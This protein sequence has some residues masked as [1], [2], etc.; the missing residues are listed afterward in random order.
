MKNHRFN[1]IGRPFSYGGKTFS[2]V[3]GNLTGSYNEMMS[4]LFVVFDYWGGRQFTSYDGGSWNYRQFYQAASKELAGVDFFE[5][6]SD[7]KI[8]VPG[9]RQLFQWRE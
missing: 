2:A 4:H 7:G 1:R 5:D 3:S 9:T 8:Y 6:L